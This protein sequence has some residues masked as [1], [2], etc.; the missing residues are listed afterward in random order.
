MNGSWRMYCPR[1]KRGEIRRLQQEGKKVAMIG[2]G[3]NDAPALARADVGV[4]IGAGTDIAMESADIVLMKS[5]L[6]DA[7]SAIKL[8]KAV[9][10]NIKENLFWAFFYNTIG[11]PI[12]AG[13]FYK[14]L[15][16]RLSPMIGAAAMSMSSVCVV[17]N[18]LR[19]KLF[20]PAHSPEAPDNQEDHEKIIQKGDLD[21]KKT[22]VVEGM[23]CMHCVAAVEKALRAVKGVSAVKVDL[24]GKV[25]EVTLSEDVPDQA[26]LGAVNEAGYQGIEVK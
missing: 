4:A 15:G 18:A 1:I 12:A 13:V 20:R 11:I 7:V 5:D 10:R 16:L 14:L 26:L 17:L 21:M 22:V 8:S 23:S 25:A 3:I 19:L 9:L 24:A 6:L 2:D